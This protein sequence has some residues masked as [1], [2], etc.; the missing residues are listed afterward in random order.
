[1]SFP[2]PD[3]QMSLIGLTP[4][5]DSP[6]HLKS[7]FPPTPTTTYFLLLQ[8][9]ACRVISLPLKFHM[10]HAIH[11]FL[12]LLT[13]YS[14]WNIQLSQYVMSSSNFYFLSEAILHYHPSM[15][16]YCTEKQVINQLFSHRCRLIFSFQLIL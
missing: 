11:T 14:T 8:K 6:S 5:P 1:M 15:H 4:N 2:T 16:A 13:L 12:P 9:T 7:P 3:L 10:C